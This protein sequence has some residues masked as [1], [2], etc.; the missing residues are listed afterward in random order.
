[1]AIGKR[2]GSVSLLAPR[3]GKPRFVHKKATGWLSPASLVWSRRA[4]SKWRL[5]RDRSLRVRNWNGPACR[6]LQFIVVH[7]DVVVIRLHP[8][9]QERRAFCRFVLSDG[10]MVRWC[11]GAMVRWCDGAVAVV[12]KPR[13]CLCSPKYSHVS[14][15]SIASPWVEKTKVLKLPA[16]DA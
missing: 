9:Y 4:N 8:P 11:D 10:A 1:M 14:G 13:L 16:L 12:K 7:V 3:G 5:C 2:R 6:I 15:C